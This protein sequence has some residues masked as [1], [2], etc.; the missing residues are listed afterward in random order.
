MIYYS[1]INTLQHYYTTILISM[2]LIELFNLH[3]NL[4][5]FGKKFTN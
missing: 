1:N 2:T 3:G 5:N 4:R